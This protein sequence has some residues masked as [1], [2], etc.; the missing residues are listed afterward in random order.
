MEVGRGDNDDRHFV[1]LRRMAPDRTIYHC[2]DNSDRVGVVVLYSAL[3]R[4]INNLLPKSMPAEKK[5]LS[6]NN[7]FDVVATYLRDRTFAGCRCP[8]LIEL[9]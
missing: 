1:I 8:I 9:P 7:T 4:Q 2:K 6:S 5:N 3:A